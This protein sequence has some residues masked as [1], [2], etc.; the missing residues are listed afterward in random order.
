MNARPRIPKALTSLVAGFGLVLMIGTVCS[1]QDSRVPRRL[2]GSPP[3]PACVI[4]ASPVLGTFEP[5][6]YLMVRGNWPAG[7]GY[8]PLEVFGD[9]SM[10][11]YGPYS[12]LR[13]TAA[14]IMGYSRG[15][16]GIVRP[17]EI[18]SFSN[19]NLPALSPVVYPTPGSY[20]YGP[21][22]NRTPPWWTSGVNWIDQQ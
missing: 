4:P 2:F 9:Q 17:A 11:L 5:T 3:A 12:P 8:S 10:S 16:D 20:Y 18:T 1:A 15:Y 13:S 21:R 7:G 14:P 22:V 19:P 6:P